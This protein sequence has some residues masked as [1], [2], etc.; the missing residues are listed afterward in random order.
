MDV[1]IQERKISLT[2]EYDISTPAGDYYARKALMAIN[3]KIQVK[4]AD[5]SI[6]ANIQGHFSPLRSKHDISM[7]D[8]RV[9]IFECEKLL[10]RVFKCEGGGDV[11]TLYEHRHLKFSVFK[12]DGQIAAFSKNLMVL[13]SGNQYQVRMNSN[14]DVL[15][16]VCMVIAINSIEFNDDSETVNFDF[17]NIGPQGRAFDESWEPQ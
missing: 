12:N 1:T 3:D 9:Y 10:T 6:V 4:S 2:S 8:G 14:A 16:I 15:L 11:F 7:A 5:G 17:G 13:G